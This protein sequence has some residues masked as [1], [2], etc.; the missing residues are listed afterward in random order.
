MEKQKLLK[1]L[2]KYGKII[3]DFEDKKLIENDKTKVQRTGVVYTPKKI[4]NFMVDNLFRMYFED[5]KIY[6]NSDRES[7]EH[8][9]PMSRL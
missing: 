5:N 8:T 9:G 3:S 6:I 7:K 2:D 4:A 1:I